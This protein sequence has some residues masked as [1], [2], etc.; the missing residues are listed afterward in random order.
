M[1]ALIKLY[2]EKF[3]KGSKNSCLDV[4][5]AKLEA[6]ERCFVITANPEI[7]MM[8][9]KI[10]KMNEAL[11]DQD[12]LLVPDGIGV[13]KGVE[14]MGIRFE[15][16][17]PGVEICE[18]LLAYADSAKKSIYLFG[19]KREVVEALVSRVGDEYPGVIVKGYSDGYVDDKDEVFEEIL[20]LEPD[21]VMVALGTPQQELLIQRHFASSKKGI[22]IGVGGSFDI[23]S[24]QKQRAPSFFIRH[25]LEW[26]YRI[27]TEPKRIKRFWNSNVKFLFEVRK[28][29]HGSRKTV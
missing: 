26:F 24:G 20:R 10:P 18:D 2:Y 16:R 19:A 17:I 25:N 13:I 6:Q 7:L 11:M 21:I 12:T 9:K 23:L 27:V 28:E 1:A 5:K 29:K 22:Y 3:Y 15:E 14:Q 8:G 4:I